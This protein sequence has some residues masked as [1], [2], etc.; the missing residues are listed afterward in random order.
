[1]TAPVLA[2]ELDGPAFRLVGVTAN[3]LVSETLADPPDLFAVAMQ[4]E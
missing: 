1:M 4:T 2:T 3:R